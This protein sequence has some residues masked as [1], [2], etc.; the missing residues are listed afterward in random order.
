LYN[1]Y[2]KKN[3]DREGTFSKI[4]LGLDAERRLGERIVKKSKQLT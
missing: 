2:F 3:D 1:D 4:Q